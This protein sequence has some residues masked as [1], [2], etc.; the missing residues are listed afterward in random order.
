MFLDCI[1]ARFLWEVAEDLM[2]EGGALL[3]LMLAKKGVV[4][5]V[6]FGVVLVAVSTGLWCSGY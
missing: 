3:D 2:K 6:K 5:D 4:G 1:S